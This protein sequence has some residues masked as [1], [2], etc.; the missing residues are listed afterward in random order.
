MNFRAI[1][2]E[3]IAALFAVRTRTRENAYTLEATSKSDNKF[4]IAKTSAGQFTRSCER[5][6]WAFASAGMSSTSSS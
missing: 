6:V 3:D 2:G 5:N 1:A 4:R